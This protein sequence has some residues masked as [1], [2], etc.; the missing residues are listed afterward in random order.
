MAGPVEA[1]SLST[2]RIPSIGG[3][4]LLVDDEPWVRLLIRRMLTYL[5][6][7]LLEASTLAQ[8]MGL[9]DQHGDTIDLLLTDVVL[10]DRSGFELAHRLLRRQPNLKVLYVTGHAEESAAV[11]DGLRG[12]PYLSKPFR[13]DELEASLRQVLSPS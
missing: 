4:V 1:S 7:S 8:A 13:S 6:F 12:A 2:S 9:A 11:R 10:A 5:G 3:T